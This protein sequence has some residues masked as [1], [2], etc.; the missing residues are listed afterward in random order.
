MISRGARICWFRQLAIVA[1]VSWCQ[2][3]NNINSGCTPHDIE[4]KRRRQCRVPTQNNIVGRRQCRL[5][6][7]QR[8][9]A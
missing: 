5:L 7:N 6:E 2:R 9:L 3:A 1:I 4:E 8:I